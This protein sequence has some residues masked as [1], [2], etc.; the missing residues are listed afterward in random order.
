[1]LEEKAPA[2]DGFLW[3]LRPRA[4]F[5]FLFSL[6]L[7]LKALYRLMPELY[8]P[9]VEIRKHGWKFQPGPPKLQICRDLLGV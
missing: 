5:L 8:S 2:D 6:F 9:R 3:A 4:R 1:M 7:F